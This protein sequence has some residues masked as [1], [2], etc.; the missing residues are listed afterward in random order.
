MLAIWIK[1]PRQETLLSQKGQG[2]KLSSL[3]KGS[4]EP[5]AEKVF[6]GS[7][8]EFNLQTQRLHD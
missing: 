3:P 1:Q 7:G 4:K 5:A 6:K 8:G 2:Q